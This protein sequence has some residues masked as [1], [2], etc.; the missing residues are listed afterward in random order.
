MGG[1][2]ETPILEKKPERGRTAVRRN[3]ILMGGVRRAP[4]KSEEEGLRSC[5]R[6]PPERE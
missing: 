4:V 5:H 2:G 6:P 1:I 3:V